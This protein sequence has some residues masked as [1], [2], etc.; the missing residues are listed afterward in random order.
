MKEAIDG[1]LRAFEGADL[2]CLGDVHELQEVG[3]FLSALVRDPGFSGTVNDIVVECGNS[4]Y[5]EIADRFT[6]GR[7]VPPSDLLPI[8]RDTTQP[9]AWDSPIYGQLFVRVREVNRDLTPERRIRVLLGDPPIH[10]DRVNTAAEL[11]PFAA[12]REAH[13]A[14]VIETQVL[15]KGRKALFWAG[16]SHVVRKPETIP[17]PVVLVE[18]RRT[19]RVWVILAHSGFPD[20]QLETR[21]AAWPTPSLLRLENTWLGRVDAASYFHNVKPRGGRNPYGGVR[22]EDAADGYLY[23]G[24]PEELTWRPAPDDIY[25]GEYGAEVERRRGLIA[26]MAGLVRKV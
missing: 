23:L 7:D 13:M 5:Q 11:A 3:D 12:L 22:L 15:R 2:V 26:G 1:V 4:A 19:G 20:E 9:G 14:A 8:W 16:S 10:W 18:K 6:A 21:L 24:P 25:D 17:N